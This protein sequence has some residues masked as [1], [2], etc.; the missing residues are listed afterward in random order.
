MSDGRIIKKY[1]NRR[2]YDTHISRYITLQEVRALVLQ[3]VKFRVH[4]KHT[5][6]D[7]T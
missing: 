4:D 5:N 3:N 7:I 1:P 2:L 6:E